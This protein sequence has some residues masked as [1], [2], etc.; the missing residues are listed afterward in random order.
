[1]EI[2]I[3]APVHVKKDIARKLQK[4][5]V[6]RRIEMKIKLGM[7][8]AVEEI[9]EDPK[10]PGVLERHRFKDA[11]T[12]ELRGLQLIY[13][14]LAER[15]LTYT[16]SAMLEESCVQRSVSERTELVS[17]VKPTP[18]KRRLPPK[19]RR[20]EEEEEEDPPPRRT[21]SGVLAVAKRGKARGRGGRT[22]LKR[23]R[24]LLDDDDL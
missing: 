20:G 12:N 5:G 15:G 2:P 10:Q 22:P 4:S 3:E 16:L 17:L 8:V 6:L 7:L 21:R 13:N 1:M 14:F 9:R 19:Q 11:A 23:S 24:T 18:V